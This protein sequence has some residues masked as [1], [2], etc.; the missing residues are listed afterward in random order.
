MDASYWGLW[1]V[2]PPISGWVPLLRAEGRLLTTSEYTRNCA[3][4]QRNCARRQPYD[5]CDCVE[6]ERQLTS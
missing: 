5:L 6:Y 2:P 3:R 1:T 4:R